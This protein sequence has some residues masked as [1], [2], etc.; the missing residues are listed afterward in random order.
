MWRP[1]SGGPEFRLKPDATGFE[2][3]CEEIKRHTWRNE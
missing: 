2:T 1:P 3:G